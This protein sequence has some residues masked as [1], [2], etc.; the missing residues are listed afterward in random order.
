[1][2]RANT[3]PTR[4]GSRVELKRTLWARLREA[5]ILAHVL[6]T[7]SRERVLPG[8]SFIILSEFVASFWTP[9]KDH[10]RR[11]KESEQRARVRNKKV[12]KSRLMGP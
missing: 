2:T 1:M 5:T 7:G 12:T 8:P 4:T 3:K 6:G 9:S 11:K 10:L